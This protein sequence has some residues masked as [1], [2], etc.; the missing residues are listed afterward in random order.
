MYTTLYDLVEALQRQVGPDEDHLVVATVMHL[1]QSGRVTFRGADALGSPLP[2][3]PPCPGSKQRGIE[4][5]CHMQT[6]TLPCQ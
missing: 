1:L 5:Q 3:L 6:S 2:G 4:S